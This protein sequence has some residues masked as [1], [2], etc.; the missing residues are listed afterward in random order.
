LALFFR[1]GCFAFELRG[2]FLLQEALAQFP[3]HY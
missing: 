2:L 1:L 3:Q